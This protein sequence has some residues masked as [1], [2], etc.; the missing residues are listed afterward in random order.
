MNIESV[1][2]NML[3]FRPNAP[4]PLT[5]RFKVC[6]FDHIQKLPRSISHGRL[7]YAAKRKADAEFTAEHL[8]SALTHQVRA[9]F[10]ESIDAQIAGMRFILP[11]HGDLD[12]TSHAMQDSLREAGYNPIVIRIGNGVHVW[13]QDLTSGENFIPV[14]TTAS[15]LHAIC[16]RLV[17]EASEVCNIPHDVKRHQALSIAQE[18]FTRFAASTRAIHMYPLGL[19]PMADPKTFLDREYIC[20]GM[21]SSSQP[22]RRPFP[23]EPIRIIGTGDFAGTITGEM[24]DLQVLYDLWPDLFEE[25]PRTVKLQQMQS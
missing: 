18:V 1:I 20:L 17:E 5:P 13:G 3:R 11:G 7:V 16:K 15:L 6:V 2:V 9:L 14:R 25:E 8:E 21:A 24:S 22:T 19:Y 12:Y 4:E 10:C 23:S